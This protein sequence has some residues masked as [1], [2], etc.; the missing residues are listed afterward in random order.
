MWESES[1]TQTRRALGAEPAAY[2]RAANYTQ[3]A[4]ARLTGCSRSTIANVETGHQRVSRDFWERA[5]EVLRTGGVLAHGHDDIEAT[6]QRERHAAA[7][8]ASG[9]RH[10]ISA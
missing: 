4:L 6:A 7:R 1:F 5:D 8:Q 9:T 3:A 2:R 10:E